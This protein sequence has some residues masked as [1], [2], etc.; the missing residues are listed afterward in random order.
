MKIYTKYH[1]VQ[2]LSYTGQIIFIDIV[3]EITKFLLHLISSPLSKF[4]TGLIE[5]YMNDYIRK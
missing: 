5:L 1:D 2:L 3:E 4:E